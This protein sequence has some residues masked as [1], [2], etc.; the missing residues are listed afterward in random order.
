MYDATAVYTLVKELEIQRSKLEEAFIND[1]EFSKV[2]EIKD[3]IN[4]LLN[5]LRDLKQNYYPSETNNDDLN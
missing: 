2:K 4:N 5:Q 1:D 3:H